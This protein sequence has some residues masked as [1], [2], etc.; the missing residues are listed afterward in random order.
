MFASAFTKIWGFT[1]FLNY[2]K[3]QNRKHFWLMWFLFRVPNILTSSYLTSPAK[4]Y[5]LFW[6][7]WYSGDFFFFF[8]NYHTTYKL[9]CP[10]PLWTYSSIYLE[11]CFCEDISLLN[12]KSR[13]CPWKNVLHWA[14]WG[15][16][17]SFS[18]VLCVCPWTLEKEWMFNLCLVKSCKNVNYF[19]LVSTVRS[20]TSSLVFC[21]FIL[22]ITEK[23]VCN[24]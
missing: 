20:S 16:G 13:L 8:F 11:E 21:S 10:F 5:L 14:I 3:N 22:S 17:Q 7:I 23:E 15:A 2:F 19:K 9:L 6:L 24:F 18:R 4:L 12:F 1:H